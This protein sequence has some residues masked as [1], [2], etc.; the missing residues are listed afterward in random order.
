MQIRTEMDIEPINHQLLGSPNP[1]NT[2]TAY[3]TE[4]AISKRLVEL[5]KRKIT[6]QEENLTTIHNMLKEMAKGFGLSGDQE[7][8]NNLLNRFNDPQYYEQH[9]EALPEVLSH[10]AFGFAVNNIKSAYDF[11]GKVKTDYPAEML[12][13]VLGRTGEGIAHH[14]NMQKTLD[15]I[16]MVRENDIRDNTN[17][18]DVV[19]ER[20]A[21][22]FVMGGH[23]KLA[24]ELL[25]HTKKTFPES[26]LSVEWG[27]AQGLGQQG[28][29]K[30]AKVFLRQIEK[31]NKDHLPRV[32]QAM[33][34]GI[35]VKQYPE[36]KKQD[37]FLDMVEKRYP[38]QLSGV[39]MSM[40]SGHREVGRIKEATKCEDR[41]LKN[42]S[43]LN[44]HQMKEAVKGMRQE[45]ITSA[46]ENTSDNAEKLKSTPRMG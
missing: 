18:L 30:E 20:S 24:Y 19:L 9:K 22:G 10:M 5:R 40:A 2:E 26:V 37:T 13:R 29:D 41:L 14:G 45:V 43:A 7:A 17:N 25:D 15:H 31:D 44:Q 33:A 42:N 11:I 4:H 27:I 16:A 28:Q 34:Y 12:P 36:N 38:D 46:S 1:L 39:L 6:A 21:G 23:N 35:G 3:W 8:A 32:L